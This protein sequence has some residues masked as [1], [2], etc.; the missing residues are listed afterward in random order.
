MNPPSS[1]VYGKL[2][3]VV[4]GVMKMYPGASSPPLPVMVMLGG[5]N[6]ELLNTR[7]GHV[8]PAGSVSTWTLAEL[9]MTM[10]AFRALGTKP[11]TVEAST[12]LRRMK[13]SMF[14]VAVVRKETFKAD[15]GITSWPSLL[16]CHYARRP[17]RDLG[18]GTLH[19]CSGRCDAERGSR[20][21]C[22]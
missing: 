21:V 19:I 5:V 11:D 4:A 15:E 13:D 16:M 10:P 14:A 12:R 20:I 1:F 9:G 7:H 17:K 8:T 6:G 2:R 3:F 22:H 18:G